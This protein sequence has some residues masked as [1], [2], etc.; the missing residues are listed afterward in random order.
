MTVDTVRVVVPVGW[1]YP[2][3]MSLV[4]P[5]RWHRAGYATVCL[6][7]A[8]I[9]AAACVRRT[10]DPLSAAGLAAGSFIRCAVD[11]VRAT[12]SH[13]NAWGNTNAGGIAGFAD[14]GHAVDG[15]GRAPPSGHP[16]GSSSAG[17]DRSPRL[18]A[19]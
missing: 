10:A 12:G 1:L 17:H 18:Y 15:A 2:H 7:G 9:V 14:V 11:G 4:D 8:V 19:S 6:L 16:F 3:A 5:S 13:R